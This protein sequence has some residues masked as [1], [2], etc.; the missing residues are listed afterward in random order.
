[1]MLSS[2]TH[3]L[4]M[5]PDDAKYALFMGSVGTEYVHNLWVP[6]I[7]G[8]HQYKLLANAKRKEQTTHTI[9]SK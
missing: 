9:E 6:L 7:C 2:H 5:I 8:Y 3:T 1:M 4:I